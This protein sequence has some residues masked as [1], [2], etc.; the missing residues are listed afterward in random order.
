MH[1]IWTNPELNTAATQCG[2]IIGLPV[3][4][5]KNGDLVFIRWDGVG[6]VF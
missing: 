6:I 3:E 4:A 2:A 5:W 1:T